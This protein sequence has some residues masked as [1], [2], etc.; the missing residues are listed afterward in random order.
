[1][2]SITFWQNVPSIHQAPMIRALA[3]LVDAMQVRVVTDA[4]LSE[5]RAAQGWS[6]P[7]FGGAQLVVAPALDDRSDLLDRFNTSDDAHVF[8]GFRAY[9]GVRTA[10]VRLLRTEA[11]LA[12]FAEAGRTDDGLRAL[13]R[14]LVYSAELARY[15]NRVDVLLASGEL[16]RAYFARAGFPTERIRKF[17]YFT[18]LPCFTDHASTATDSGA[19]SIAFVGAHIYRKRLDLLLG[20][21]HAG[22]ES[23]WH[24]AIVGAGELTAELKAHAA[25]RLGNDRV[26]WLGTLPNVEMS[27]FLACQDVLVLPSSFDGWGAVVNEALAV[28]T[29]VIASDACGASD[30]LVNGRIGDVFRSGD[31]RSLADALRR[32]MTAGRVEP[33]DRTGRAEWAARAIGPRAGAQYL[34]DVLDRCDRPVPPWEEIE[35][36]W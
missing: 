17:A 4:P 21:L 26:T 19:F 32:R 12:V 34:V 27:P 25:A 33:L 20:A 10:L 18:E 31:V 3:D 11:R 1:M 6:V 24:L 22:L 8:S 13:L 23:P 36:T 30:L 7:D 29:P 35:A 15:R 2:R 16:G 5:A 9:P 14:R 28:G